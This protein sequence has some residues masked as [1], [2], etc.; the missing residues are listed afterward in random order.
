MS[1]PTHAAFLRAVNLGATRKAPKEKLIE[2]FE[3]LG[4]DEVATFRTSGNV[5]FAG[6]GS[7][8]KLTKEIEAGLEKTLGFEVP[9]F[10]RTGKQLAAIAAKKPFTAK[11]LA[12][13]KGKLQVALLL[14]TAPAAALR[15]VEEMATDADLLALDGTELYW[16]PEGGTPESPLDMKTID[17]TVGLN[18]MRTQGT[19]EQMA[20]KFFG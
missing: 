2:C 4:F 9:V 6:T 16:L 8:A 7:A 14:K 19:I 11:Q 18:T 10:L 3:G 1:G 20:E 13:S 15:R 17:R 12:A 5:V